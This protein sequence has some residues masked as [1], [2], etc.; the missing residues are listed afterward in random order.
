MKKFLLI[1]L[2]AIATITCKKKDVVPDPTD[3]SLPAYT[4]TNLAYGN[5]SLQKLD[6]YLPAGR[7]LQE[8]KV[9][10]LIHGGGWSQGDKADLRLY[11]DTLKRRLPDYAIF[12]INYRLATGATN[13]FPTQEND[14]KAAIEFIHSKRA[15][16]YLTDKYVLLGASA[17]AHLALLHAY[18]NIIPVRIKA[19]VDFYG[20]TELVSLYNDPL[21]PLI[22]LLLTQVTGGSPSTHAFMYQQSSPV[23]FVNNQTPPTMILQGGLDILVSPS[24]AVLLKNTLDANAVFNQYV[25]Y[26]SEGHVWIGPN[27]TDSFNKIAAFLSATVN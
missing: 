13:L 1:S 25:Y 5:D 22:P 19:V 8:S 23:N 14:V 3:N 21:N 18:K 20:P 26:P 24:Q 17:G 11:V 15:E 6:V 12:N 7:N 10:I 9:I 4:A 2:L 27:L 16:F